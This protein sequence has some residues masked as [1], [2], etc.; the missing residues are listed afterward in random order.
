M[1]KPIIFMFSGQGSQYYHMGK[2][3]FFQNTV[4]RRSML[5]LNDVV[6][7]NVG[8]SIIDEIYNEDKKRSEP[9]D[10]LLYTHPAIFMIEYSLARTLIESGVEPD[11]VLGA[12]LGEVTSAAVAGM[13]SIE[14]TIECLLKRAELIENYCELGGMIA[15]INNQEL[16]HQAPIFSL[17][18]ELAA[19]NYSSH[20][21]ISGTRNKLIKIEEYLKDRNILFQTLPVRYGFHSSNI[22]SMESEYKEFLYKSSFKKAKMSVISCL[23]SG[24]ITEVSPEF[25]WDV[26]RQPIC[27]QKTIVELEKKGQFNYIDV[28]PSGTLA[29]FVKKIISKDSVSQIHD[30]LTPFSQGIK[31]IEKLKELFNVTK[32][33]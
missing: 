24:C 28:G 7:K 31:K 13:I 21:V 16:Y 11:Y 27:F 3:L 22:D 26:S 29:T 17:N 2:E 12:S 4:F 1:S 15:I 19:I 10:R 5:A 20:F 9:F 8:I 30:I 6:Y 18:S 33:S 32:L 25:F 14:R 23:T